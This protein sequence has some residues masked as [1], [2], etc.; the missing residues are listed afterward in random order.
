[1]ASARAILAQDLRF[2]DVALA[3]AFAALGTT[4]PNPAVGCVLVKD[5]HILA[6]AATAPGGRPH[7]ETQALDIAGAQARG[8]TAY[9]T[10]EPCAHHGRTPPCA[11]ALAKAG[12]GEVIIACRDPFA[13]VDGRGAAILCEA[14]IRVIDGVRRE[15]AEALNAG[16]FSTVLTGRALHVED[17]RS[18]LIDAVV[19]RGAGE[20]AGEALERAAKTG[21][22]R[23]TLTGGDATQR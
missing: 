6:A 4:A 17:P 11:E 13:Q 14:G 1:M 9:V 20:S 7:A 5:G 15:A 21:L 23:V 19:E 18:G 3:H 22:T 10:L 8:A 16:F 12:V 2:M